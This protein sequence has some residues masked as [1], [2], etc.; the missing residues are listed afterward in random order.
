[1]SISKRSRRP[2]VALR[3]TIAVALTA[4]I[5]SSVTP[6]AAQ[7]PFVA[8]DKAKVAAAKESQRAHAEDAT[9]ATWGAATVPVTAP[10]DKVAS[11]D[12]AASAAAKAAPSGAAAA[13]ANAKPDGSQATAP[14][15]SA[16]TAE[17]AVK[18]D[19]A[20]ARTAATDGTAATGAAP[21]GATVTAAVEPTTYD[22]SQHRDPFRPP[23]VATAAVDSSPRTPLEGYDLGQLKLV[24]VV[25]ETAGGARAMVEDSS[26]L[27]YIVTTGTPIGTSGGVVTRIEPRRVLIEEHTTNFYGDKEPKQVVMELPKE[28]RSP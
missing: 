18:N 13:D 4:G 3:V 22:P 24:G 21:T 8:L 26:G 7:G 27:G 2:S 10:A 12:A 15:G 5:S 28:D 14:S 11:G 23:G 16:A 6:A 1:M 25:T 17:G 20:A 19:D 9:A